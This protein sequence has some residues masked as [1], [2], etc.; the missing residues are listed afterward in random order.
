MGKV[1]SL[2]PGQGSHFVGMGRDLFQEYPVARQTFEEANAVLGYDLAK[3]C[4]TGN[5]F[6]KNATIVSFSN[7]DDRKLLMKSVSS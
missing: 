4:F 3:I 2:F 1:A 6:V 5:L 7:K